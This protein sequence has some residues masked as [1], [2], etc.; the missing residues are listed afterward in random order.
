MDVRKL[1]LIA[2]VALAAAS[3]VRA[4][5]AEDDA[6]VTL[7]AAAGAPVTAAAGAAPL[8]AA[9]QAAA[10]PLS[11]KTINKLKGGDFFKYVTVT[12]SKSGRPEYK[13]KEGTNPSPATRAA[14]EEL[15]ATSQRVLDAL[16]APGPAA[17]AA[18]GGL[19][20]AAGACDARCMLSRLRRWWST[21]R[22]IVGRFLPDYVL[23]GL[24]EARVVSLITAYFSAFGWRNFPMALTYALVNILGRASPYAPIYLTI[25][26]AVM[27]FLEVRAT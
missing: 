2:V 26:P 4:A 18:A 21:V 24:S 13:L 27:F 19:A 15:I 11:A 25:I 3:A 10:P 1:A 17:A 8:A 14:I 5:A 22:S 7:Q 20:A 12:L 9:V 16:D 6:A 23:S